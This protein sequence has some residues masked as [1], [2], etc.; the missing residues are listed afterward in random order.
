MVGVPNWVKAEVCK[1]LTLETLG[2]Q[3]P[4]YQLGA[5]ASWIARYEDYA[6]CIKDIAR[7]YGNIPRSKTRALGGRVDGRCSLYGLLVHRLAQEIFIL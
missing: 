2:V 5:A 7:G 4:P 1:T 6:N 3:V